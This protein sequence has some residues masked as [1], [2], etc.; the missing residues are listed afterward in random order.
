MKAKAVEV[1]EKFWGLMQSNDFRSVGTV[2]SDDFVLEWPQSN[3]RISGRDNFILMNEEY[4]AHGPWTFTINKLVGNDHD[5]VTDVS[6]TDG[7]Q[8]ARV[9]SFFA[10][11][12]GRI[13]RMV[14]FWPASYEPP[15]NRRHLVEKIS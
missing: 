6:V 3:E 8:N 9:I 2:L 13:T 5:A 10:V 11:E 7:V 1:I 12:G 4:P 14:E 15:G